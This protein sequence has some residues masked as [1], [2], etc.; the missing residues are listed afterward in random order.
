MEGQCTKQNFINSFFTVTGVITVSL[1]LSSV[2]V[3]YYCFGKKDDKCEEVDEVAEYQQ[4][5]LDEFD[6]LKEREIE[7]DEL[8]EL[9]ELSLRTDTPQGEVIMTYGYET[10]TF[11]YY[12]DKTE[13]SYKTLET[14]ARQFCINNDCKKLYVDAKEEEKNK[15]EADEKAEKICEDEKD[16]KDEKGNKNKSVFIEYKTYNA[17]KNT[18]IV[19]TNRFTK[20]GRIDEWLKIEEQKETMKNRNDV[21]NNLDFNMFKKM[22]ASG[23]FSIL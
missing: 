9:G 14:V 17:P 8:K 2:V 19:K 1:V 20:K 21:T 7:E 11:W 5:F 16:K 15:K 18:Y 22:S 3:G 6:E 10:E 12:A 23:N 13:I 4:Q